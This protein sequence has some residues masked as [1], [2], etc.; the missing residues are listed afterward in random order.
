MKK[1]LPEVIGFSDQNLKLEF[2]NT[3]PKRRDIRP[4][5]Y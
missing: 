5:Q 3:K 4:A 2:P 1:T